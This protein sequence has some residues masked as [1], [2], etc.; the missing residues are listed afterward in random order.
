ME[1]Y[2]D[3]PLGNVLQ[4]ATPRAPPI[5]APGATM[6]VVARYN[7]QELY[8]TTPEDFEILM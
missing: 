5:Y 7:N 2:P 1:I 8:F 6:H 3:K 4:I